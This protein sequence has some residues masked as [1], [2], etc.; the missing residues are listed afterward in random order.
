MGY[1]VGGKGHGGERAAESTTHPREGGLHTLPLHRSL[2]SPGK[3]ETT[4]PQDVFPNEM[5][6]IR[7]TP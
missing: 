7:T 3:Q 2:N 6:P 1:T 4:P 5:D